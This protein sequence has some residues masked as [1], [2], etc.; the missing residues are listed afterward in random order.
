MRGGVARR[1]DALSGVTKVK[2]AAGDVVV[3]ETA[4]RSGPWP[5]PRPIRMPSGGLT[6]PQRW[7]EGASVPLKRVPKKGPYPLCPMRT[8]RVG[9]PAMRGKSDALWRQDPR[10]LGAS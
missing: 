1:S 5:P 2:L 9:P 8:P 7:R 4:G 6:P 10:G 3:L